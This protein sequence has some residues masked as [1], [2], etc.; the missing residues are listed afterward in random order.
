MK[1]GRPEITVLELSRQLDRCCLVDVREPSEIVGEL[2]HIAGIELLP[3]GELISRLESGASREELFGGDPERK[4]V[5]VC[6]S[7]NRSGQACDRL[8]SAGIAG[9]VNMIGGM[10]EWNRHGLPVVRSGEDASGGQA[11]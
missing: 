2:G 7:G 4:V 8:A 11:E 1:D 6:R 3:L 9:A 5:I 10:L